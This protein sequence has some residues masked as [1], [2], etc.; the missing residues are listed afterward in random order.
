M[1]SITIQNSIKIRLWG[2]GEVYRE[3]LYVDDLADACVYLMENVDAGR[4]KELSEDYFVNV[5]TG[6]DIK[7]KDL[8]VMIRDIIGSKCDVI[9]DKT[10]PDGTPRK[11]LDVSKIKQL[12]W[13]YKTSLEEG[14]KKTYES[15]I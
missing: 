4:M 5:G 14:I 1:G 2:T 10:K 9:Y 15:Y 3:F 12:G 7:I 8:S 13:K 6:E 11:L